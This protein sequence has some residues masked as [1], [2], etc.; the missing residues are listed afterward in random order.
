MVGYQRKQQMVQYWDVVNVSSWHWCLLHLP[1]SLSACIS[2]V[3][4]FPLWLQINLG[5]IRIDIFILTLVILIVIFIIRGCV[6]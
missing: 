6:I 2:V 5:S 4:L 1:S 3:L